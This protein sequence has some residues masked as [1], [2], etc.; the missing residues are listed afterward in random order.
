MGEKHRQSDVSR[1]ATLQRLGGAAVDVAM[2]Q[3]PMSGNTYAEGPSGGEWQEL[4]QFA[5]QRL[6]QAG[7]ASRMVATRWEL[8]SLLTS[9]L[10]ALRV[11]AIVGDFSDLF[12]DDPLF[13]VLR[14]QLPAALP[15]VEAVMATGQEQAEL[16][17]GI[18]LA[19]G[20]I[21]QTGTLV[22][23][24]ESA[25]ELAASLLPRE[26]WVVVPLDRVFADFRQ[27]HLGTGG[28]QKKNYVFVSGPSRTADIEKTLV[29]GV[30]GPWSVSVVF[31]RTD[32][33]GRD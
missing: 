6:T 16:P 30:H 29:W 7:V 24:A 20:L 21:A 25:A 4:H 1:S 17:V 31:F 11:G 23:Q 32:Q 12:P 3:R 33:S 14:R 9:Q 28:M 18:T 27:W 13:P 10:Y 2:P 15:L 22:L 26:H 8:I 5:A 19:A